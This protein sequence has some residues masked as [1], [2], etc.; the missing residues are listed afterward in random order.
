MEAQALV[1]EFRAQA[2]SVREHRKLLL[3]AYEN[4]AQPAEILRE[5]VEDVGIGDVDQKVLLDRLKCAHAI[6][7]AHEPLGHDHTELKTS[8]ERVKR[9]I[10]RLDDLLKVSPSEIDYLRGESPAIGT[11]STHFAADLQ[12]K[13]ALPGSE[14]GS[15][16]DTGALSDAQKPK[17]FEN[18]ESDLAPDHYSDLLACDIYDKC[19]YGF[20]EIGYR[21][22]EDKAPY[23]FP[24][25]AR[26][27]DLIQ[28][29]LEK[30]RLQEQIDFLSNVQGYFEAKRKNTSEHDPENEAHFRMAL[31]VLH[32]DLSKTRSEFK[33]FDLEPL[34]A[35]HSLDTDP[36]GAMHAFH[37][38]QNEEDWNIT[39]NSDR[40]TLGNDL[41]P[42]PSRARGPPTTFADNDL[43]RPEQNPIHDRDRSNRRDTSGA[44]PNG[45]ERHRVSAPV[46]AT[47]KQKQINNSNVA[48]PSPSRA[49]SAAKLSEIPATRTIKTSKANKYRDK[50]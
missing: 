49:S 48:L 10:H 27:S 34:G 29:R 41:A 6:L 12:L 23:S 16:V 26:N 47:S 44:T 8:D 13:D 36:H 5:L 17:S 15:A 20:P 1:Q 4:L 21:M 46:S 28:R 7:V 19:S 33:T 30:D 14:T 25:F 40:H 11:K 9:C 39:D 38:P 24:D 32:E 42:L 3:K 45:K 31:Q 35:T 2:V 43:Q 50:G 37:S 18:E 22:L